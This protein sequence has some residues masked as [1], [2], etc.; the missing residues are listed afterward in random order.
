MLR[1]FSAAAIMS[2]IVAASAGCSPAALL[3]MIPIPIPGITGGEPTPAG[4]EIQLLYAKGV[5]SMMPDPIK[6]LKIAPTERVWVVNKNGGSNNDSSVDALTYD[7]IIDILRSKGVSEVV[8]RDDDMMRS[9]YVEYTESAKLA[10]RADSLARDGKIQPADV[11]VTY[12]LMRLN[13]RQPGLIILGLRFIVGALIGLVA[14]AQ[15]NMSDGVRLVMHLEAIDVKTGTTRAT[16]I[17]E[18]VERQPDWYAADYVF[19]DYNGR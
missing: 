2:L 19:G 13:T 17:A 8:A 4:E 16:R 10:A 6:D 15:P 11:I 3:N 1:R 14:D 5:R 18:H 12:R 7:A 9:L